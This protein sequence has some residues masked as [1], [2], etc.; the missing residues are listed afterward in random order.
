M[1]GRAESL[2]TPEKA[3]DYRLAVDLHFSP[4]EATLAFIVLAYRDDYAPHV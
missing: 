3:L 1:L 2:I 4:D